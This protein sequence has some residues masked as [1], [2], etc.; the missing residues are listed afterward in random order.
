MYHR[1]FI[2]M[3]LFQHGCR[4]PLV[5]GVSYFPILHP[6]QV[7]IMFLDFFFLPP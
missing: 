6:Q 3:Q 4:M 7:N 1:V 2:Y 5:T